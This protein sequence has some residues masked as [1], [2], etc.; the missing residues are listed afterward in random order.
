[1][2][3]THTNTHTHS[4]GLLWKSDRPVTETSTWKHT[5]SLKTSSHACGGIRIRNTSKRAAADLRLRKM[6]NEVDKWFITVLNWHCF[7]LILLCLSLLEQFES[8]LCI[9]DHVKSKNT[10]WK[11]SP[12][13]FIIP[14]KQISPVYWTQQTKFLAHT[15]HLMT[16]VGRNAETSVPV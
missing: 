1:M 14:E 11:P 7:V 15:F 3:H 12:L 13:W 16:D 9:L 8:S 4:V 2:T 10:N 6:G 5:H